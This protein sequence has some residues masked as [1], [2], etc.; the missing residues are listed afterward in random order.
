VIRR[1]P[2]QGPRSK[3]SRTFTFGPWTSNPVA[4]RFARGDHTGDDGSASACAKNALDS[5]IANW[6]RNWHERRGGMY[7]KI[8][9]LGGT[10]FVGRHLVARLAAEDRQLTLLS[11]RIE[12]HKDLL[13]LPNVELV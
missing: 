7:R 5:S 11:R 4:P 2:G 8:C 13:V 6:R 3:E 9:V 12:H 10:G 1:A